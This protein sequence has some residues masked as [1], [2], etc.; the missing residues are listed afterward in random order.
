MQAK[1]ISKSNPKSILGGSFLAAGIA[2]MVWQ[3]GGTEVQ[4]GSVL[5]SFLTGSFGSLAGLG[6][7]W[8][9]AVQAAA[10]DHSAFLWLV[11][12]M[13]VSFSAFGMAVAGL[14]LLPRR[15]APA[16]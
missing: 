12:K 5:E 6:L 4:T 13:L 2:L 1:A 7:V 8:L 14:A 16:R 15:S 3:M 9:E 11:Y 10:F